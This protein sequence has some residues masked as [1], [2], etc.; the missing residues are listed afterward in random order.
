MGWTPDRAITPRSERRG[1]VAGMSPAPVARPCTPPPPTSAGAAPQA[2]A[3]PRTAG[4]AHASRAFPRG[5]A[6]PTPRSSS[7]PPPRP[8]SEPLD[9]G[10]GPRPSAPHRRPEREVTGKVT[11]TPTNKRNFTPPPGYTHAPRREASGSRAASPR[12]ARSPRPNSPRAAVSPFHPKSKEVA[13][14]PN[15]APAPHRRRLTAEQFEAASP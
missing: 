7:V 13:E 12:G 4:Y 14:K 8:K 5:S 11:G 10:F 1:E 15:V 6:L 3:T 2:A 9:D